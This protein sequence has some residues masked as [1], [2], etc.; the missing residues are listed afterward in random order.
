VSIVTS[1]FGRLSDA[2]IANVPSLASSPTSITTEGVSVTLPLP[3]VSFSPLLVVPSAIV[4]PEAQLV[5]D[6]VIGLVEPL[7]RDTGD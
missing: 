7:R 2:A 3:R 4:R 6:D 5:P 1:A